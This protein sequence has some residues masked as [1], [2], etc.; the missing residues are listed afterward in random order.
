MKSKICD[1]GKVASRNIVMC[2]YSENKYMCVMRSFLRRNDE[3]LVSDEY[4]KEAI[5]LDGCMSDDVTIYK[6]DKCYS[7]STE[8]RY[9]ETVIMRTYNLR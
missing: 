4:G 1:C 9:G 3:V 8:S 2:R 6:C 5:D 7:P